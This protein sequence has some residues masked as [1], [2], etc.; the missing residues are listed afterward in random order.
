MTLD[1]LVDW[2]RTLPPMTPEQKRAQMISFA[3]GNVKL[4]NPD[5]T[6]EDIRAAVAQWE[7]EGWK[8]FEQ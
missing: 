4:S 7:K 3:Y 8:P 2:A 1:E 6:M 5:I